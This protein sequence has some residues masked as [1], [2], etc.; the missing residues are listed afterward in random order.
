VV[1]DAPDPVAVHRAVGGR[2]GR[3]AADAPEVMGGFAR[4]HA[5]ARRQGALP[6]SVKELMA[7][8]IAV[9]VGCESCVG[10]H[11]REAV[12]AGASRDE[13]VEA[14]G[15]AVMMG[16]GPAVV[17]AGLARDGLDV[18]VPAPG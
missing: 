5:A 6:T 7:L 18:L 16:G 1:T 17:L 8:A 9:A 3:L 4:L 14:L 12:A 13:V 11:V 15:V 2:T 10:F